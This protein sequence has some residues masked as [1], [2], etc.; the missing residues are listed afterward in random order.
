MLTGVPDLTVTAWLL[1][2]AAVFLVGFAKTS[3]GGV[4]SIAVAVFAAVLPARESTGTLLPLLLVGDVIAVIVYRRH[5]NWRLLWRLFP[6]VAVGTVLGA[7]F[8]AHANDDLMRR[9]IGVVLLVLVGLQLLGRGGR[10]QQLAQRQERSV[11]GRRV[12]SAVVGI[13]AGVL[14]MVANSAGAVMTLYLLMSGLLMLEFLGTGAWFFLIVNSF[15]V[16]FS[17]ALGLLDRSA[18]VLDLTLAPLVVIGGL[19]GILTVRRLGQ[20]QFEWA[21]LAL[22]GVAAVPLLH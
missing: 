13:A 1:I 5:T 16:P 21:A 7:V 8:V 10:L 19:V 14:T 4:A 18:L 12:V 9:C 3:I 11:A 2:A 6:W 15:K 20:R 22:V 17:V